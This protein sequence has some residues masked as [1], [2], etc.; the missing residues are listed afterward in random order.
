[1]KSRQ[2]MRGDSIKTKWDDSDKPIPA[3]ILGKYRG[4]RGWSYVVR[5]QDGST[6]KITEDQIV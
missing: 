5:L 4:H 3:V 1:M 2:Y 6:E